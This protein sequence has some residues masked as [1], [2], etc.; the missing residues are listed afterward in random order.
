MSS[1]APKFRSIK[2]TGVKTYRKLF[3][4]EISN[5]RP[6]PHY[7]PRFFTNKNLFYVRNCRKYYSNKNKNKLK[8]NITKNQK[9]L[10]A[11]RELRRKNCLFITRH[12]KPTNNSLIKKEE[13]SPKPTKKFKKRLKFKIST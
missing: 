13:Q 2:F 10:L 1:K 3:N 11:K 9:K 7:K 6:T 5:T 12:Y 8:L 4:V